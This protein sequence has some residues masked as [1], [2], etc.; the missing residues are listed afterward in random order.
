MSEQFTAC[1]LG[2]RAIS[3]LFLDIN[4]WSKCPRFASSLLILS[5]VK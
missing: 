5:W 4:L 2:L 3:S 1:L